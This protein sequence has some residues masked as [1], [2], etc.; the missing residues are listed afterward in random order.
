MFFF[1]QVYRVEK[2]NLKEWSKYLCAEF[3]VVGKKDESWHKESQQSER[4]KREQHQSQVGPFE[5]GDTSI[6]EPHLQ[7][8]EEGEREVG[9]E[10]EKR[11][12]RSNIGDNMC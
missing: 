11:W 2:E 12:R 6:I 10:R 4:D 5:T 3:S 7:Q 1:G 8:R 9:V